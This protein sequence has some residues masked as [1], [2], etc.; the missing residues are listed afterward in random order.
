MGDQQ[1]GGGGA[2]VVAGFMCSH[3]ADDEMNACFALEAACCAAVE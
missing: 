3:Y 1:I 2:V